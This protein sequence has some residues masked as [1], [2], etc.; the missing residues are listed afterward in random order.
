MNNKQSQDQQLKK[1]QLL[2]QADQQ[3]QAELNQANKK[4]NQ[5]KPDWITDE[6]WKA[7]PNVHHWARL[8]ATMQSVEQS[9]QSPP[10][11]PEEFLAHQRQMLVDAGL[12]TKAFDDLRRRLK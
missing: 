9:R 11:T 5:T 4:E 1:L 7:N 12:S 8:R 10:Q 6:Q 2:F 3:V